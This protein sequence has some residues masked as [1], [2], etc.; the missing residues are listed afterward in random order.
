[1]KKYID[2]IALVVL[3]LFLVHC[4]SN[5]IMKAPENLIPKEQMVLVL[6]DLLL[7]SGG[8]QIKNVN[9][10]RNVNYS[11]LVFDK[12]GIDSTRFK[13]SNLFYASRI[14][15]YQEILSRVNDTLL[16]MK[17]QVET[18]IAKT[19]S[20]R[21]IKDDSLY[22]KRKKPVISPKKNNG[23]PALSDSLTTPLTIE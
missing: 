16:A 4:T 11:P 13:E 22:Q 17:D 7:A 9:L 15:E 1:M 19:D 21:R 12:Y 14:D 10:K 20:I 18:A 2:K 6:T 5:T 3:A 8:H 23:R